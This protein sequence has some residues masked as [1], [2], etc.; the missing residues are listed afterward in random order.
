MNKRSPLATRP[1]ALVALSVLTACTAFGPPRTPPSVP[2]PA[3]YSIA[4]TNPQLTADQGPRQQLL[5]GA[6]PIPEWWRAFGS[7]QLDALVSEALDRNQSLAAAQANLRAAHE[8][9]R[10]QVGN[11]LYPHLDAGVASS[12]QRA[13]SIPGLPQQT[14]L[15]DVFAAEVQGSWTL[16]LFGASMLAD[17]AL[18]GQVRAQAYDFEVERRAVAFNVVLA[19]INAASLRAQIDAVAA[20]A[21]AQ[22]HRA[23]Q[24]RERY[25]LGSATR[26]DMLSAEDEAAGAQRVLPPLRRQL[27]AVQHAEAVLLGRTPDAAPAPLSLDELHLP[28]RLPVAVPSE[29][30]HQRPDILAA[31]AAVRA[32]ADAAGAA[33]AALYPSLTLSAAYGRG[34]FDWSTVTSPAGA[35]WSAG[36]SL[37]QPLFHGGALRARQRQY[38]AAYEA[39]VAQYRQTVLTAF[40]SVADTLVS[41]DEDTKE[42]EQAQRSAQALK[43][44]QQ[45]TEERYARGATPLYAVLGARSQ[46][47]NAYVTYVAARA[48]RLTDSAGLLDAM[49]NPTSASSLSGTD[50]TD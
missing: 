35:I 9:V 37:T 7:P 1:P 10:E 29:L 6:A 4:P 47:Q 15:Y 30:L 13:L 27:L 31:E 43:E 5:L 44:V 34:G 42:L 32:G 39:A 45:E 23:R 33:T 12:R 3:H 25:Q 18:L 14:F 8:Q 48:T 50:S 22:E 17:R 36:A 41:L 46:Y 21:D 24:L 11:N 19:A 28:D 40:Q 2:S 49:G 26:L 20:Y 16:D 38:Q